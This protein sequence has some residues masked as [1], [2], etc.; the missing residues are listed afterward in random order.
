MLLAEELLLLVL[1]EE[2]GATK[3][4]I[5]AQDQG[6]AGAL[7]LDLAASGRLDESDGKLVASGSEPSEAPLAAAWRAIRAEA[8]PRDAKHW[9]GKLPTALKPIKGTVAHG[10]VASGVLD[11]RRHKLLGLFS[12]TRY[13][14]LDP[15]AETELRARLRGVLVDGVEPDAR[16]ASLLRLLVPM[17]MVKRL[18]ERAERKVAGARAKAIA[19][20]GPVGAAVHA[21]V[22]EQITMAVIGATLV[23]TSTAASSGGN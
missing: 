13:P 2:K 14:E 17:D 22:Q 12:T 19:E 9:V 4:L 11:E 15:S 18:V 21:A 10:L 1:D 3:D 6:L 23:A 8:K 7:L 5:Y 20:R 16:T